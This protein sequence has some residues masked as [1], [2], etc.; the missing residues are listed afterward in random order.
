ME[1]GT[2]FSGQSLSDQAFIEQ[3]YHKFNRL[4]FSVAR[5]YHS[6]PHDQEDVVQNTTEKLMQ[7]INT[8]RMLDPPALPSYITY[9]ARSVAVDLLRS[10]KR[11]QKHVVCVEP[12]SF[13]LLEG[14]S[15]D[16]GLLAAE[17]SQQLKNA[18]RSLSE[19]DQL[20]LEGKYIW[21]YSDEV[22]AVD[23]HCKASSIRMKLTRARRRALQCLSE[24]GKVLLS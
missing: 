5:R 13:A 7:R 21:E 14:P 12:E 16:A 20:L 6:N 17:R 10:Q 23:F 15:I 18:W 11:L 4:M 22:L 2:F 8:L 19:E 24:E 9:T 3:I 1:L